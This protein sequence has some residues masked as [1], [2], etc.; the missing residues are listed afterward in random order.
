MENLFGDH[1]NQ[2][3]FSVILFTAI[4]IFSTFS[5]CFELRHFHLNHG[6]IPR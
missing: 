4:D 5:T 2:V 6:E 1:V 3:T